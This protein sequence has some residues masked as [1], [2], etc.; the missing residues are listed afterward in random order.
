MLEPPLYTDGLSPVGRCFDQN[1]TYMCWWDSSTIRN[2]SDT[3]ESCYN[4]L[5]KPVNKNTSQQTRGF[6]DLNS[7]RGLRAAL[8]M[9]PAAQPPTQAN[10]RLKVVDMAMGKRLGANRGGN[11]RRETGGKPLHDYAL[12]Q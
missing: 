12:T 5:F 4:S 9:A 11:E 6:V 7:K 10:C 8:Y 3:V 1:G 2:Y